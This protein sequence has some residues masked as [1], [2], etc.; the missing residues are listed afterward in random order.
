MT[1]PFLEFYDPRILPGHW[2]IKKKKQ[3]QVSKIKKKSVIWCP[4]ELD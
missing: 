4:E 3:D 2:S 1:F